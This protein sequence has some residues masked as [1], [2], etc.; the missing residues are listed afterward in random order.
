ME[1]TYLY[2]PTWPDMAV[3]TDGHPTL[4]CWHMSHLLTLRSKTYLLPLES[5]PSN[6]LLGN[7]SAT[8]KVMFALLVWG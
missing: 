3:D 6:Y 8:I 2:I 4:G 7:I 5:M 1:M